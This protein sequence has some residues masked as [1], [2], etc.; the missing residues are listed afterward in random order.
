VAAWCAYVFVLGVL[1]LANGLNAL[2]LSPSPLVMRC[3]R[4]DPGFYAPISLAAIGI[5]SLPLAVV[6]ILATRA[7]AVARARRR[8]ALILLVHALLLFGACTGTMR[9]AD[10]YIRA[11]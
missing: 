9:L 8:M 6:P 7:Y 1:A 11:H 4:G 5:L 2:G 3:V 10:L